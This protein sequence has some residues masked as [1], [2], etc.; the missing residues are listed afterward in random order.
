[1]Q[2]HLEIWSKS[3]F[4]ITFF[5]VTHF[6]QKS[7]FLNSRQRY[8]MVLTCSSDFWPKYEWEHL[9]NH[10]KMQVLDPKGANSVPPAPC[11][12]LQYGWEF[13]LFF[14]GLC[15]V[16][17]IEIMWILI[18][19]FFCGMFFELLHTTPCSIIMELRP[20]VISR[21]E[22]WHSKSPKLVPSRSSSP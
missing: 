8:L 10:V 21:P 14:L 7:S 22:T 2:N 19:L 20:K 15:L 16:K 9:W 1:M 11:L 6:S 12:K 5:Y 13:V 18:F 17:N 4:W 3:Q